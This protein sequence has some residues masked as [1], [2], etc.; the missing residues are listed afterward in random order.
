MKCIKT[1]WSK[2]VSG[3]LKPNRNKRKN[4]NNIWNNLMKNLDPLGLK[5]RLGN[6]EYGNRSLNLLCG[7]KKPIP[8]SLLTLFSLSTKKLTNYLKTVPLLWTLRS[9]KF[10]KK[11]MTR[12]KIMELS[13]MEVL[14]FWPSEVCWWK[15]MELELRK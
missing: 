5:L 15:D 12:S 11:D 7:E 4:M 9:E 2:K 10:T 14:K 6:L 1:F 3:P 13:I 8:P